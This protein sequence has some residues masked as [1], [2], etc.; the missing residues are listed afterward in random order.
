M[1]QTDSYP[2]TFHLDGSGLG[3][4]SSSRSRLAWADLANENVVLEEKMDGSETSFEFDAD[5]NPL[6]CF[7]GSP[8]DLTARGGAERPFDRLKDWFS[9]HQDEFFDRFED[10]YRVYGEWLYA[11]HRIFY[12][13]LPDYFLE[14]DMLDKA[15]GVFLDTPSRRA[16]LSDLYTV[17]SV[18]VIYEGQAGK[19][20]HPSKFDHLS[21]YRSETIEASAKLACRIPG[22]GVEGFLARIDSGRLMEGVYGKVEENGTVTRRFKWVRP[23]F[24][25]SIAAHGKHWRDM[26]L[27]PNLL[28][29]GERSFCPDVIRRSG[30]SGP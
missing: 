24:V 13:R 26:P 10:R 17:H 30:G 11:A 18:R 8:L 9:L 2:R 5:A 16:L 22:Q 4:G 20:H 1:S 23:D 6:V 19:S 12:D 15:R 14:F 28:A 25:G 21:A 7:R 3:D 27:V 29:A